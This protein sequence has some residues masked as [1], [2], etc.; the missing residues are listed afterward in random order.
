M[1]VSLMGNF[2]FWCAKTTIFGPSYTILAHFEPF[3]MGT[4]SKMMGNFKI[5]ATAL[6]QSTL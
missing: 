1:P 5:L 6:V 4:L 3:W 2:H